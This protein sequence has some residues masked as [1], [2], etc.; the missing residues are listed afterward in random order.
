MDNKNL[1]IYKDGD[2]H[3]VG[4]VTQTLDIRMICSLGTLQEEGTSQAY[5][6]AT[7]PSESRDIVKNAKIVIV[8]FN[9][10][11]FMTPL[12]EVYTDGYMARCVGNCAYDLSG[13]TRVTRA[14]IE[15]NTASGSGG[16]SFYVYFDEE[17][18][19]ASSGFSNNPPT[20]YLFVVV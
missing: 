9:G 1:Y 13:N 15:C 3:N 7:I 20:A 10:T 8:A 14:R 12:T 18:S 2:F 4:G 11:F 17:F 19:H 5:Y 6:R 16:G